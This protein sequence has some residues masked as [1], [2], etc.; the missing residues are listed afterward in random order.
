M[1]HI[2][3]IQLFCAN[4]ITDHIWEYRKTPTDFNNDNLTNAP[5]IML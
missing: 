3:N 1:Q 2:F 4:T 5:V